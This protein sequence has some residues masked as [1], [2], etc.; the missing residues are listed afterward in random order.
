MTAFLFTFNWLSVAKQLKEKHQTTR[1]IN[2]NRFK[3][4]NI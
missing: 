4:T 1:L 3:L 2:M